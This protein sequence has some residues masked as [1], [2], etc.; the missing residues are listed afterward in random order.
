MTASEMFTS[1]MEE[2]D[3][4]A[5]APLVKTWLNGA[6]VMIDWIQGYWTKA[7]DKGFQLPAFKDPYN[8]SC[9]F[10]KGTS[11]FQDLWDH[12]IT[13]KGV[14][15]IQSSEVNK[16]TTENDKVTGVVA[17]NKLT[18]GTI[19]L[20]AKTVIVATGGFGGNPAEMKK[21]LGSDNFYLYGLSSNVGTGIDLCE[22]LGCVIC[23]ELEP[24]LAEFCGN[25]EVDFYAGYMKF[26]NQ[27]G[28]LMVD[29][30][31]NRFVNEELFIT[32]ALEAG[33]SALRRVG[34]A[35]VLFT[36]SDFDSMATQGVH[37]RL[38]KEYTDSIE[39]RARILVDSFYTLPDEMAEALDKG[40]A[41][42]ADTIEELIEK[43][44]FDKETFTDTVAA[45]SQ[46]VADNIDPEFG[47]SP[48]LV[49][50]FEKG[51]FYAVRVISP[52]DNTYNGVKVDTKFR[53]LCGDKQTPSLGGLYVVGQDSGNVFAYPYTKYVGSCS[54]YAL[55]SGMLS[56]QSVAEYL[57][58]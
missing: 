6:G 42:K 27:C 7:G 53:P 8:Y 15:L 25:N 5:N 29:P 31:G 28:F 51:P 52:I 19:T 22:G 18:G 21:R 30:A 37:G 34:F 45:Y 48:N 16:I 23:E 56:V 17:T 43:A 3:Y 2:N 40:E 44:G 38:T 12:F 9:P 46:V 20:H 36:Q 49:F 32:Q 57:G 24:A 41:F 13:P 1:M 14:R 58:R 26:I 11:K 35:Y 39:M 55:T 47:K 50:P 10:G 33:A 4:R 54:S